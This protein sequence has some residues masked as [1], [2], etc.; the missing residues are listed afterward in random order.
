M[1]RKRLLR[2]PDRLRPS[3]P[4]GGRMER[5]RVGLCGASRTAGR[6]RP[7]VHEYA[8]LDVLPMDEGTT[9]FVVPGRPPLTTTRDC[10]T[11]SGI[12]QRSGRTIRISGLRL[13]YANVGENQH[14][15]GTGPGGLG[16]VESDAFPNAGPR[17]SW[18]VGLCP[19]EPTIFRR[20]AG[21]PAG[22]SA[23]RLHR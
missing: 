13:N 12:C 21:P 7:C 2:L 6:L 15:G 22:G 9:L 3:V 11:E 5:E 17:S 18:T 1:K 8:A 16:C 4:V 19:V 23:Q 10:P 20:T 14:K